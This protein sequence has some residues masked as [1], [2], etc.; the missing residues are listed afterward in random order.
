MALTIVVIK[1]IELVPSSVEIQPGKDF[2]FQHTARRLK[3]L[4]TPDLSCEVYVQCRDIL[5]WHLL[6][7]F[8]LFQFSILQPFQ[9]V[10]VSAMLRCLSDEDG[11]VRKFSAEAL[12][13]AV[14]SL[15][16]RHDAESDFLRVQAFHLCSQQLGHELLGNAD[17]ET[18]ASQYSDHASDKNLLK[19]HRGFEVRSSASQIEDRLDQDILMPNIPH[20]FS[21]YHEQCK[22]GCIKLMM[23]D[24]SMLSKR[25]IF[26]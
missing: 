14:E 10:A 13:D 16:L 25:P 22:Q 2:V 12:V 11:R 15:S 23:T 7:A 26:S 19:V 4:P 8:D 18:T 1:D 20:R 9:D 3:K 21:C 24:E 17:D 5:L 6:R